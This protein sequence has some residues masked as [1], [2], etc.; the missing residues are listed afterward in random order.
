M[1]CEAGLSSF[2]IWKTRVRHV[3]LKTLFAKAFESVRRECSYSQSLGNI[4]VIG[5]KLEAPEAR[6]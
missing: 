6:A 1:N 2:K 4:V 5:S 3:D